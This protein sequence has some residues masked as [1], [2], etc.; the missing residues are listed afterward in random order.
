MNLAV[1]E[2]QKIREFVSLGPVFGKGG[3]RAY[4]SSAFES[5]GL[6]SLPKVTGGAG[7]ARDLFFGGGGGGAPVNSESRNAKPHAG[8]SPPILH[9]QARVYKLFS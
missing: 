8:P 9:V 3:R 1:I 5:L 4:F 7:K 2:W 6:S